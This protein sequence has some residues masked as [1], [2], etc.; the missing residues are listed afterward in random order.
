MIASSEQTMNGPIKLRCYLSAMLFLSALVSANRVTAQTVVTDPT[1]EASVRPDI[2]ANF[3][4]EQ[5][6]PDEW[7]ERFEVE[8]RE[9]YRS[10]GFIV[11]AVKLE[12]EDRVA[13]VGAG[14]GL[15]TMLFAEVVGPRG[16][17]Y[18]ID[19]A[20]RFVERIGELADQ[21]GLTNVDPRLGDERNVRLPPASID[22]AF[23]CD[24]YHHFEYP[25]STLAS[26][27]RAL[28]PGG[29]FVV[30][31]FERIPGQSREWIL[32]HVRAGK[33]TVR[34]EIENA[35]FRFVGE[36]DIEGLDENYFIVFQKYQAND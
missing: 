4:D 9:V 12:A 8:S 29:K 7:V 35:G 11:D 2:N 26:I 5:L 10:R 24:T 28:R 31:D 16:R 13:D 27:L 32:G 19:I 22:V 17:V 23:V 34:Q 15:F 14:T 33:E 6:D 25:Q 20:P 1:E 18:A 36:T 3:L 30:V 21:R